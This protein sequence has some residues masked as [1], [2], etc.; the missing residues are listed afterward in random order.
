MCF[1]PYNRTWETGAFQSVRVEADLVMF[2]APEARA[3]LALGISWLNQ[4]HSYLFGERATGI[5]ASPNQPYP[6]LPVG[7][8]VISQ[9]PC[10][11]VWWPPISGHPWDVVG[12][13]PPLCCFL[14]L[15]QDTQAL[16]RD[17]RFIPL[18]KLVGNHTPWNFSENSNCISLPF[19]IFVP[20]LK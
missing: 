3:C 15:L 12:L 8:L 20:S 19:F 13:N 6:A 14:K 10:S 9:M 18:K 11:V 16:S 1:L 5:Q 7:G 17:R 4:L 2:R